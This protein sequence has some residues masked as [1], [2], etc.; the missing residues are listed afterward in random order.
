MTASLR[1]LDAAGRLADLTT[2]PSDRTA[3]FLSKLRLR[4]NEAMT[5]PYLASEGEYIKFLDSLVVWV[6][7]E[8][9]IRQGL[10]A[11]KPEREG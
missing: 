9:R 11:K 8:I 2:P 6:A 5:G 7:E 3:Q 10:S 1:M 4:A